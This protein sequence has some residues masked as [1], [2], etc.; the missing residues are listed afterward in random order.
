MR[1]LLEEGKM[2]VRRR[3]RFLIAG[4]GT[5]NTATVTTL[6]KGLLGAT[7]I[8]YMNRKGVLKVDTKKLQKESELNVVP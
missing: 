6:F 4:W 7:I 2:T 5:L 8:F 1:H 3:N